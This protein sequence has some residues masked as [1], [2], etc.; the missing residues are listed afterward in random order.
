MLLV[1]S[2]YSDRLEEASKLLEHITSL[3]ETGGVLESSILK[4]SYTLLL[5]NNLEATVSSSISYIHEK[6]SVCKYDDL[7][8]EFKKLYASFYHFDISRKKVK[9]HLDGTVS[10][11][12][13]FPDYDEYCKRITIFSG[14]IDLRSLNDFNEKYG[15]GRIDLRGRTPDNILTIKNK[16]NKLAH[17]EESFRDSCRHYTLSELQEL[18]DSLEKL[19][20]KFIELV[21]VFV[22][23]GRYK[24]P[25]V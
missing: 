14:N 8:D 9:E 5:Y 25:V 12:F 10:G 20:S 18:G 7:S 15:I 23:D 1:K 21:E 16:R 19:L 22:T 13:R 17:G 4:S 24:T 3:S 11:N 2:A 6:A